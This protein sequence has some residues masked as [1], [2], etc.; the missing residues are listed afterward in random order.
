M[1]KPKVH[2]HFTI[3]NTPR[4]KTRDAYTVDMEAVRKRRAIEDRQERKA[5]KAF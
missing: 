5:A 2:Q 1:A 3:V 4:D